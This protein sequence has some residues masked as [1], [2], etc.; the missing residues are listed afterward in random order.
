MKRILLVATGLAMLG[1]SA[2]AQP[3]PDRYPDRGYRPGPPA[4][5]QPGPPAYVRPGPPP[6]MY[7]RPRPVPR[8]TCYV[9][10]RFGGG[11]CAAQRYA[12]P[13]ERCGC[14]GPYG[15]RAGR[16]G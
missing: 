6:P 1:T 7:V 8:F 3:Y 10:P 11:A 14:P 5:V 13:G 4:Y 2:A 12:R 15:M 9:S 16:V